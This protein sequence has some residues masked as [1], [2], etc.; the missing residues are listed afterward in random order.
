MSMKLSTAIR[1]MGALVLLAL[2]LSAAVFYLLGRL[3]A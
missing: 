2:L 1:I 3:D